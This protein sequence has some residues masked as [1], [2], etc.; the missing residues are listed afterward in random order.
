MSRFLEPRAAD[1][2]PSE[3]GALAFP[4]AVELPKFVLA[5]VFRPK[6][7]LKTIRFARTSDA[8]PQVRGGHQTVPYLAVD[9]VLASD[10]QTYTKCARCGRALS[11]LANDDGGVQGEDA[12]CLTAT[13][14]GIMPTLFP[15]G[16]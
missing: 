3:I 5:S 16:A 1:G 11:L 15:K 12:V 10:V 4:E 6:I 8:V 7:G 13:R 9:E 14:T 2:G